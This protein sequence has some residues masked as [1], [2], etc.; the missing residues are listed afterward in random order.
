MLVQ[1]KIEACLIQVSHNNV[2]IPAVEVKSGLS[3]FTVSKIEMI[4]TIFYH[5]R[6]YVFAGTKLDRL[7]ILLGLGLVLLAA[8]Y[9]SRFFDFAA[10]PFEDAAMLMRYSQHLAQGHGI[11]WNIGERPIDGATDFLFMV[12]VAALAK[13]GMS[14]ESSVRSIGFA[15]HFLTAAIIYI[16]IRTLYGARKW[17][18]FVSAAYLVVGPGLRYVEAYFGTVLFALFACITWYFGNRLL[19]ESDHQTTS[20]AFALSGFVMGLIRPEGVFLAVFMLLSVVYMRGVKNSKRVILHFLVTFSLLGGFYFLWRWS[21]FGYPLPNPFYKKGGGQLYFDS[22]VAS[23]KNAIVL[24]FA[25]TI[26]FIYG[27]WVSIR[28]FV[29]RLGLYPA[30]QLIAL[31]WKPIE[32]T[33]RTYFTRITYNTIFVLIPV[34]GFTMLWVLLSNEMNHLGRFQY[35]I[36]PIILLSWPLFLPDIRETLRLQQFDKLDIKLRAIL[37]LLIVIAA[38]LILLF[39][40]KMYNDRRHFRD[41]RYDVAV[42]LDKFSH[43]NY[44]IATTEAGLIPLYSGWRAIDTWGLND[45]WIAHN[46]QITEEYLA[47]NNPEIIIF[48][49]EY[50][51]SFNPPDAIS[52]QWSSMVMTLKTYAQKNGYVLA[53][54]FGDYPNDTHYY[55]VRP[56]F[57]ES[58]EIIR[59]IRHMDYSW[60]KS[61]TKSVNYAKYVIV[62]D[63]SQ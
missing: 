25:F 63:G 51:S 58:T 41:G 55:Y 31:L 8:F 16:S 10:H 56:D 2:V 45:Q 1:H 12:L 36:V 39:Q 20:L 17:I 34:L 32:P 61:G 35:A 62:K 42:A 43:L 57:P 54:V 26:V 33:S 24:S 50:F 59:R 47:L 52:R 3:L 13:A 18:A 38:G 11:V 30:R 60:Y 4:R 23:I 6:T 15:A 27:I 40:H 21:Y 48:H 19:Q 49:E 53:A 9:T 29:A 7:D 5:K 37:A 28:L 44:T 46:G 14:L 22:L